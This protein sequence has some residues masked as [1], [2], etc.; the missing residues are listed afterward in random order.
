MLAPRRHSLAPPPPPPHA[1]RA[2]GLRRALSA[3]VVLGTPPARAQGVPALAA[4]AAVPAAR[5]RAE[6][7][8]LAEAER[9]AAAFARA[10]PSAGWH[11]VLVTELP[12]DVPAPARASVVAGRGV[13]PMLYWRAPVPGAVLLHELTHA[14]QAR[15]RTTRWTPCSPRSPPATGPPATMCGSSS[16]RRRP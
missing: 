15:S 9:A 5:C 7:P 10:F 12:A 14:W 1:G 16:R 3:A 2:R 4:G 8:R 11:E 6:L 13:D